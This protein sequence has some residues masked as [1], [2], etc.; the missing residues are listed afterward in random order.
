MPVLTL[1]MKEIWARKR[2]L[3]NTFLAVFLGVAFLGGVL[4]LGDTLRSNFKNLFTEANAGVD[5]VVRSATEINPGREGPLDVGRRGLVDVS[6]LPAIQQIDGVAAA[7]PSIQGYGQLIGRDGK[8]VGGTGP[9]RLAGNW[10]ADSALNPYRIVEGRPPQADDEVVINRGAAKAGHLSIGDTTTV[11]TPAPV[12]VRIVGIA[13]YG[14]ADGEGQT[15]FT[16]FTLP[17]AQRYLANG[18]DRASSVV[19]RG[20]PGVTQDALVARVRSAVP[21]GD[22]VITGAQLSQESIDDINATFLDLLRGFLTVFAGVAVLV[23]AF[24]IFNTFSILVT[25]RMRQ[26][27]LLRALGAS[28]RQI[29]AAVVGEAL[30][31]GLVAS[32]AGVL[33][34]LGV[35]GLL[36]GL[37]DA[38]GFALPAGG[39][40]PTTT[41]LVVPVVVGT[42]VTVVASLVPALKASRVAPLAALRDTAVDAG[43][44]SPVRVVVG[45]VLSAAGVAATITGAAAGAGLG[46]AALGALLTIIGVVTSGPIVARTASRLIG[47]PIRRW[48]GISGALARDNAMRNP[49][50]TAGT[51]SALM[52]GVAVVTLFTVF[53][54]SLRASVDRAVS[55]TFAGDLA[56]TTGAFGGG[57]LSPDLVTALA[58]LPQVQAAAGL[59]RGAVRVGTAAETVTVTDPAAVAQVLDL[60][61]Q[62]GAVA[63]LGAT[64]LAVSSSAAKSHHWHVGSPVSVTFTDGQTVPFTIGAVYGESQLVGDYLLSQAAWTPHAVQN[65]DVAI[66]VSLKNGVSVADGRTAVRRAAAPFGGPD[67]LDRSA[68]VVQAT[69]GISMILGLVYVMLGLAILIALMGIANTLALSVHERTRELGLLRAVGAARARIRSMVRWESVIIALFGTVGGLGVGL[70]LGWALTTVAVTGPDGAFAAPPASL[71]V[72]LAAGGLAGLLAALRPARRAARLNVLAAIAME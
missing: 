54:A 41:S 60:H 20:E 25:Q 64:Q 15:T 2:R 8:A 29:V 26:S 28:R 68:Y 62:S 39:L 22:E 9:P 69:R 5:A 43:A 71:A 36:K 70:F 21:S 19:V 3:V 72:V 4:A 34:G 7:A 16:A 56:V 49:R 11:Q 27:A 48:R 38:I 66:F 53:A 61:A 45:L 42:G 50:R 17:A 40:T 51:A 44:T 58:P 31:V 59:G 46:V 23:G 24:S 6:L 52:V 18:N 13:T 57:A 35:A 14:S 1:T 33:A 63:S 10:I 47:A 30:V 65:L 67:V 12:T 37:F 32:V 55:R